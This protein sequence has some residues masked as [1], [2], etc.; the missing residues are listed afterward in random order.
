MKWLSRKAVV[1]KGDSVRLLRDIG[2]GVHI[3]GHEGDIM[4]VADVMPT[5]LIVSDREAEDMIPVWFDEVEPVPILE[6]A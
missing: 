5:R 3:L 6:V 2:D 4:Y 1:S